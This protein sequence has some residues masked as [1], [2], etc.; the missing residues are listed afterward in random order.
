M[1]FNSSY[2]L[3]SSTFAQALIALT[4]SP[5]GRCLFRR[6]VLNGNDKRIGGERLQFT[7]ANIHCE[8][9]RDGKAGQRAGEIF[10]RCRICGVAEMLCEDGSTFSGDVCG[11]LRD[12]GR[13]WLDGRCRG[14][15]RDDDANMAIASGRC[16]QGVGACSA[17]QLLHQICRGLRHDSAGQADE[18]SK[19]EQGGAQSKKNRK[20]TADR[21][22]GHRR[23][24][25]CIVLNRCGQRHDGHLRGH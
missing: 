8:A 22:C 4:R 11:D 1:I 6:V 5:C 25:A 7:C 15:E 20:K 13:A 18:C 23:V 24:R 3:P 2:E 21:M 19:C 14:P 10:A 17:G 9:R 12:I 16:Q